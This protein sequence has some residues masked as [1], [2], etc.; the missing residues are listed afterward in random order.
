MTD[1]PLK[2]LPASFQELFANEPDVMRRKRKL[3]GQGENQHGQPK[4]AASQALGL[5][6]N[7]TP[8]KH[9]Y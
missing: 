4:S 3:V 6:I 8:A 7:Y 2:N 5:G 9:L 1:N